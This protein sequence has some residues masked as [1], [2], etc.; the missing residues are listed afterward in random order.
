[1]CR[2]DT[3]WPYD[4][5][6]KRK[7]PCK[8][9]FSQDKQPYGHM[10]SKTSIKF[11]NKYEICVLQMKRY[12][13]MGQVINH[14]RKEILQAYST[15][16]LITMFDFYLWIL[17]KIL[18]SDYCYVKHFCLNKVQVKSLLVLEAHLHLKQK[19]NIC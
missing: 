12:W 11:T 19:L 17:T 10:D 8:C 18:C 1:M 14:Y 16:F 2:L 4:A 9:I 5:R 15:L 3:R 7:L 6:K 13:R